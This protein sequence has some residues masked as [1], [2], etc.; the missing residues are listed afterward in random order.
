MKVKINQPTDKSDVRITPIVFG[1]WA[2]GGW[3]W[4]GNDKQAS[5]EALHAAVDLGITSIDTAPIYGYG[6]SEEI[7]GEALQGKRKKVELL[8]K[9]G[10]RWDSNE[11]HI[12]MES[13]DDGVITKIRR[14]ATK[15]SIIYEVEQSLKR[16]RTDYLD[17]LQI[18]W[19]DPHTE[20]EETMEAMQLLLDQGK[21]LAA[22]VSNYS[23][24]QMEEALTYTQI[25]TNQVPYSMVN[26]GIENDL[27]PAAIKNKVGI[28]AYSP[29]QRGLL[30]GKITTDYTFAEGDHRPRTPFFQPDFIKKTNVFLNELA[31]IAQ[32]KGLSL[33]Q[34]VIRWTVE[35]PGIVGVLVGARNRIQVEDNAKALHTE[36]STEE[37]QII[38]ELLEKHHF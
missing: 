19:P 21:I 8:T 10:L 17:L 2:I 25:S 16:L 27:I 34:L 28:L 18:H 1:A 36:L 3:M 11:G 37:L 12:H 15:E 23:T 31:D 13:N 35:Q 5:I 6:R 26:R 32:H 22:G 38:K 29:L 33:A 24:T 7:I 30:T 14:L 9:F 4:G 20:I